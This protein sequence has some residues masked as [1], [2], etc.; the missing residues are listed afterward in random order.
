MLNEKVKDIM[1]YGERLATYELDINITEY[2]YKYE[3]KSYIITMKN[4]DVINIF[5]TK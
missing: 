4:G 3:N 1:R 2:I 5:E